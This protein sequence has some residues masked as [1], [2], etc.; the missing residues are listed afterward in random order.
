MNMAFTEI[1]ILDVDCA[2]V[3]ELSLSRNDVIVP[4][5]LSNT[6]PQE[7]KRYFEKQAPASANAKIVGNTARYK[8]PKNKAAIGRDGACWKMV[9]NL[10]EHA[11]RYYLEIELRQELERQVEMERQEEQ[12]PEFEKEWDRYMSRD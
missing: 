4:Y 2:H 11:N 10:V 1:T 5:I 6:P 3:E 12:L 9:S 8:C 7:W